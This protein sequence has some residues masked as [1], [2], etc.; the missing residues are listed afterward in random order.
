MLE[1]AWAT[2]LRSYGPHTGLAGED[3]WVHGDQLALLLK[4]LP[5]R[6]EEESLVL[7]LLQHG[8]WMETFKGILVSRNLPPTAG[9]SISTSLPTT[10]H[11]MILMKIAVYY[12]LSNNK[13]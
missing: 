13:L 11:P 12:T 8:S 7:P 9:I 4:W 5:Q 1:K 3:C 10:H 2:P 6:Q